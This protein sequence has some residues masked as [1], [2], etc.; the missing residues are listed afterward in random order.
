MYAKYVL[1]TL[2]R[3]ELLNNYHTKI[4]VPIVE[5]SSVAGTVFYGQR[6]LLGVVSN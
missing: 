6:V 3:I 1:H 4:T 5:R 2:P